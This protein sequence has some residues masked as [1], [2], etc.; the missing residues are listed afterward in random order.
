MTKIAN[1]K[2]FSPST[3]IKATGDKVK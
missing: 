1:N 2:M 3:Q